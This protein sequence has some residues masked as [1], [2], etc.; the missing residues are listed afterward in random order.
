VLFLSVVLA[1]CGGAGSGAPSATTTR[2]VRLAAHTPLD[3][4]RACLTR[5]NESQQIVAY[6]TLHRTITGG[7]VTTNQDLASERAQCAV[8]LFIRLFPQHPPVPF[9]FLTRST[10]GPWQ[11]AVPVNHPLEIG[12]RARVPGGLPVDVTRPLAL[13]L[14]PRQ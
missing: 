7:Y 9:L 11:H 13:R 8:L 6:V 4:A 3:S 12:A 14:A 5:F 10:N 1:G 2:V